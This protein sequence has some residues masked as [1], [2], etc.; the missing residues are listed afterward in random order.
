[1]PQWQ[2]TPKPARRNDLSLNAE[3][4]RGKDVE[5]LWPMALPLLQKAIDRTR[6]QLTAGV[7]Y[8]SLL[9]GRLQ[10]WLDPSGNFEMA[11]VTAI[12]QYPGTRVL[13]ILVVGGKGIRSWHG[14]LVKTLADFGRTKNCSALEACVRPGLIGAVFKENKSI[15]KGWDKLS[16][17]IRK[18]I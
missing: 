3:C 17:V 9:A 4:Y 8:E 10:L 18:S 14:D 13:S 5:R 16:T 12:T 6:G 11:A 15:L 1:V 2:S 7:I